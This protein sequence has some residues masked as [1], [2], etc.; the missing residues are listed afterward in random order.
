MNE[1][2][3]QYNKTY[4][5]YINRKPINVGYS[6]LRKK[7]GTNSK[8]PKFKVNDRVK[9]TKYKNILNK[10]YTENC[11]REISII[12]FVLKTN[13]WAYKLKDLNGGKIIGN[14]YE[15]ELL[16]SIYKWVITQNQV[17]ILDIKSK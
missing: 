9:I 7:I 13:S 14:F 5:H 1:L 16:L 17:V 10:G 4:H 8:A 11:S 12:D 6:A 3:D 15:K 2:I